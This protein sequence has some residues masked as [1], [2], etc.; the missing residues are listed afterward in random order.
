MNASLLCDDYCGQCAFTPVLAEWYNDPRE[1]PEHAA[2]SDF[3]PPWRSPVVAPQAAEGV[4]HPFWPSL[5]SRDLAG[6]ASD[7]AVEALDPAPPCAGF[8][9][10]CPPSGVSA[11]SPSS[12]SPAVTEHQRTKGQRSA[13]V[14][15]PARCPLHPEDPELRMPDGVTCSR[16]R[17]GG[18]GS[19]LPSS[20]ARGPARL[21]SARPRSAPPVPV[22][23]YKPVGLIQPASTTQNK[24]A[25]VVPE[26]VGRPPADGCWS[27]PTSP[28]SGGAPKP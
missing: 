28:L 2:S 11:V 3:E 16:G 13:S 6:E 15:H 25:A 8:G 18:Q 27:A 5:P 26:C 7:S 10:K 21:S 17:K 24:S 4:Q 20:V 12:P 22:R 9:H 1:S 14:G 19:A 23:S